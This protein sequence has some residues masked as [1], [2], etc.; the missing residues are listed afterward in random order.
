MVI[1][2]HGGSTDGVDP[3]QAIHHR[4]ECING[5]QTSGQYPVNLRRVYIRLVVKFV[6]AVVLIGFGLYGVMTLLHVHPALKIPRNIQQLKT[7]HRT[8]AGMVQED[9]WT[10]YIVYAATYVVL[11][12]FA[13]PGSIFFTIL[14]GSI[15]PF[16]VALFTVSACSATGATI[17]YFFA[18]YLISE[19]LK[20]VFKSHLG[21]FEQR[22]NR[23]KQHLLWYMIFLRITPLVP[24]W[25][26]TLFSPSVPYPI[27]PFSLGTFIGVLIPSTLFVQLGQTIE[28]LTHNDLG[29][30]VNTIVFLFAAGFVSLLPVFFKEY[31]MEKLDE[32]GETDANEKK[33]N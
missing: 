23:H 1:T 12:A 31:L 21:E 19:E 30:S 17:C 6:V 15:F 2:R 10:V 3:D 7:L 13:I 26:I 29:H 14:G 24:N 5:A 4:K 16:P 33:K 32:A 22:V 9:F 18:K 20:I 27:V 28:T 11:Q 25:M 8:L